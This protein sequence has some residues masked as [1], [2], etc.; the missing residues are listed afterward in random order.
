MS[1]HWLIQRPS[2]C[3]VRK[4]ICCDADAQT[5]MEDVKEVPKVPDANKND[6]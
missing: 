2:F 4:L 3:D 6:R 1:H 5:S